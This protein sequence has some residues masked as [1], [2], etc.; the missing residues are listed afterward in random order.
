MT[1]NLK[2]FLCINASLISYVMEVWESELSDEVPIKYDES[3]QNYL[4]KKSTQ[5]DK[6]ELISTLK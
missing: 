3:A 2:A 1:L 5:T 6:Y 4:I